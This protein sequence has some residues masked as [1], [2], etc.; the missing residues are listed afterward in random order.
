MTNEN[1]TAHTAHQQHYY[2]MN[3]NGRVWD[4]EPDETNWKWSRYK[5][6]RAQPD[7]GEKSYEDI[8]AMIDSF[9]HFP[10]KSEQFDYWL[11]IKKSRIQAM[12]HTELLETYVNIESSQKLNLHIEYRRFLLNR[13]NLHHELL[14]R[15][16]N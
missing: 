14:H 11:T 5:S 12:S 10:N 4:K 16:S 2:W 13:D 7:I 9:D 6:E 15:M 1:E 3:A 8:L